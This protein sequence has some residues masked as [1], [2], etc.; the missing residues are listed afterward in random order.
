MT[1]RYERRTV[2]NLF[3]TERDLQVVEAV[4]EARYLTTEQIKLLFF[5]STTRVRTRLRILFDKGYLKKR[6]VGQNEQDVYFLGVKGKHYIEERFGVDR[7]QVKKIAGISGENAV[8]SA[9]FLYHELTLSKIYTHARLQC[10]AHN[11]TLTWRNSR[12]LEVQ[13]IGLQPD[14][15]LKVA[16]GQKASEAFIEFTY[17]ITTRDEIRKKIRLYTGYFRAVGFIT[18]LWFTTSRDKAKAIRK[19]ID[20]SEHGNYFLVGMV[21]DISKFLTEK[22][23]WWNESEDRIEFIKP[24]E[25]VL[26]LA[27]K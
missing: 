11:W 20:D 16:K 18:V 2:K 21:D 17:A 12:M 19:L 24:S 8:Q 6:P 4:W 23:W 15:Y 7:E 1:K 5:G 10:Q 9:Q 3:T 27:R 22:V 26:Y 13:D 14:A 25:T